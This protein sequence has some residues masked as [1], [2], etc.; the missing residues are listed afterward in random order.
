M[1]AFSAVVTA[2]IVIRINRYE[3]KEKERNNNLF[4]SKGNKSN[5]NSLYKR[6][7]SNYIT[8]TY[9]RRIAR[10]YELLYPTLEHLVAKKTVFLV[11]CSF[12]IDILI[13]VFLYL[14]RPSM[15]NL[16]TTVFIIY[17]LQITILSNMVRKTELQLLEQLDIYLSDVKHFYA[18]SK[19]ITNALWNTVENVKKEFKPHIAKIF[20]IVSSTNMEEDTRIYN[21]AGNNKFLKLLL[22]ICVRTAEQGDSLNNRGESVFTENINILKKNIRRDIKKITKTNFIFSELTAVVVLPITTL[23]FI[24]GWAVG[25]LNELKQFYDGKWGFY[26]VSAIILLTF[27]SFHLLEKLR[28]GEDINRRNYPVLERISKTK[29]IRIILK[30]RTNK[31]REK[32]MQTGELLRKLGEQ[33]SASTLIMRQLTSG[34]IGFVIGITVLITAYRSEY[35]MVLTTTYDLY[36]QLPQRNQKLITEEDLSNWIME[37]KNEGSEVIID[38]LRM[39]GITSEAA[40]EK[41]AEQI[42]AQLEKAKNSYIRW[43]EFGVML[44]FTILFYFYPY[45][46]ILFKKQFLSDYMTEEVLSFQTILSMHVYMRGASLIKMLES[47]ELFARVF[48]PSIQTCINDMNR[49]DLI[50]FEELK[51]SEKFPGFQ[52]LVDCFIRAEQTDIPTSFDEVIDDIKHFQDMYEIDIDMIL[53]RKQDIATI[54]AF[55]PGMAIVIIYLTLP[56][57]IAGFSMFRTSFESNINDITY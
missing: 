28:D 7:C 27:L 19:D 11:V 54:I 47:M 17:V 24:K 46:M 55:A 45:L 37:Y 25:N 14:I 2:F 42:D 41:L 40:L 22:S 39:E 18:A 6:L 33:Y 38:R 35:T 5:V 12:G 50:A 23:T 20:D 34:F 26:S 3:K 10:R 21:E 16:I 36:D 44:L 51:E 4:I 32:M 30:T 48:K 9:T 43:Y 56:F 1:I 57:I 31:R 29:F 13:F 52:R 8:G 53:K 15:M 49:N